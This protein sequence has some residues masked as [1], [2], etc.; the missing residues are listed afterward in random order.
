MRTFLH[1]NNANCNWKN[2]D[3]FIA[4]KEN[5][6]FWK[7]FLDKEESIEINGEKHN[8]FKFIN[9]AFEE[10]AGIYSPPQ[11]MNGYHLRPVNTL[12]DSIDCLRNNI[13]INRELIFES[14]RSEYYPNL[15]SR[16]RCIWLI[17]ENHESLNF[18]N[19]ILEKGKGQKLFKV[20]KVEGTIHWSSQEWLVGGT[21]SIN[22]WDHMTS[23]YWKGLN[24]GNIEDEILY[25]GKIKIIKESTCLA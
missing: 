19:N 4:G 25:E 11:K 10:Y 8:A 2:G 5:N 21:Y 24:S 12:K 16:Q 18:W 9:A 6:N 23:N 7:S 3:E 22:H 20:V 14:I 13:K 1:I 15:P 17:S